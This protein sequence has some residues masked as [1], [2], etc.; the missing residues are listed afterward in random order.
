MEFKL[1]YEL[2]G[3]QVKIEGPDTNKFLEYTVSREDE[4]IIFT[5]NND[6]E[7]ENYI[8]EKYTKSKTEKSNST[9]NSKEKDSTSNSSSS[10]VSE[11]SSSTV[12]AIESSTQEYEEPVATID[13]FYGL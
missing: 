5:P 4:K 10:E 2:K 13:D 3:N 8:L 1:E 11:S 12:A 6:K 9:K 7:K